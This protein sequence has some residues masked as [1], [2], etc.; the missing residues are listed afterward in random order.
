MNN[1]Y[2]LRQDFDNFEELADN[3]RLWNIQINQLEAGEKTHSITQLSVGNTSIAY[4]TFTGRTHQVGDPPTMGTIAF[5]A[6]QSSSL[7]W[8][9]QNVPHNSLMIFPNKSELD[10]V[11]KGLLN[12]VYTISIP[13]HILKFLLG[14]QKNKEIIIST[15]QNIATLQQIIHSSCQ[16]LKEQPELITSQ[17]FH[18]S[19]ENELFDAVSEAL[20]F[21][22]LQPKRIVNNSKKPLWSK[23]ED[24]MGSAIDSPIYVTELAKKTRTSE[25]TLLRLFKERFGISTKTYLNFMR[26]NGVRRDLNNT[27]LGENKIADIANKWGFWHMGQFAADYKRLFGQLP[28]ET[29]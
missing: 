15:S 3:L 1:N 14:T 10:A 22:T 6:G 4:G 7:V 29:L 11:T 27:S 5:H 13:I 25:R 18:K 21:I 24:T 20:S 12:N 16:I 23:I 17:H 8:R 2:F 28:S 19:F 9:K 26:L